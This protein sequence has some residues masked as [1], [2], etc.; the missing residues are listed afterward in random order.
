MTDES[1]VLFVN[2]AYKQFG[3]RGGG[4]LTAVG[5]VSFFIRRG[6]CL[7]VIGESGCGKSTLARLVT[8]IDALTGGEVLFAGRNIAGLKGA[9]L[10]DMRR[11]MQIILQNAADAIS[12]RMKIKTFLMEPWIN[13]KLADRQTARERIVETLDM[14]RLGSEVLEHYPH[15]LS[16]G[17]LQRVCIAR[18]FAIRPE[19]LVCDEIT[20]ALDVSVQNDVMRLF[21][22]IQLQTG[23]ACLMICHDLALVH[24]FSDRVMVMYLGQAVEMLDSSDLGTRAIHPYTRGLLQAMFFISGRRDGRKTRVLMGEPPSPVNLPRGCRFCGRCPKAADICAEQAPA[25]R[26]VERGHFAACHFI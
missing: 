17:E 12:P 4:T 15:Q 6:E 10:R 22:D 16:G 19:L 20:S 9:E 1:N 18:A 7:A 25:F 8:G 13:F 21:R 23:T 24:D 11:N 3:V 14:V 26:E 2:N 5:G